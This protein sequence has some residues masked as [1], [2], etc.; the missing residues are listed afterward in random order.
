MNKKYIKRQFTLRK[1]GIP[2][3]KDMQEYYDYFH[4]LI[5]VNEL[6]KSRQMEN[7]L[8]ITYWSKDNKKIF[9]YDNN[10]LDFCVKD[11]NIWWD[12]QKKY[13][14]EYDDVS[15][16]FEVMLGEIFNIN[17]IEAYHQ[18]LTYEDRYL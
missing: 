2:L 13:N 18:G 14:F 10:Y 7:F 8:D 11:H 16:L 9:Y 3:S 5:N 17:I 4:Q 6:E 1:I 15:Y 12:F